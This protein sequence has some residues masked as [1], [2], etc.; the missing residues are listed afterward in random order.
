M[1][2]PRQQA[3]VVMHNQSKMLWF[4][5]VPCVTNELSSPLCSAYNTRYYTTATA[6]R[7]NIASIPGCYAIQSQVLSNAQQQIRFTPSVALSSSAMSM[8][9]TDH[10]ISTKNRPAAALH[11][12]QQ[13]FNLTTNWPSC[14]WP[15]SCLRT[16][17]AAAAVLAAV[18]VAAATVVRPLL[19]EKAN[20][21]YVWTQKFV[22][23]ERALYLKYFSCTW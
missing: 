14:N 5:C 18:V 1:H 12:D 10:F 2:G 6:H 9:L 4:R 7:A 16:L 20:F 11:T 22:L 21:N 17:I 8:G 13:P 23:N 19:F 3:S 15:A